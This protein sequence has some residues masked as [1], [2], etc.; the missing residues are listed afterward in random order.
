[1][2]S[3]NKPHVNIPEVEMKNSISGATVGYGNIPLKS[4]TNSSMPEINVSKTPET[5]FLEA[6]E[7]Y[8]NYLHSREKLAKKRPSDYFKTFNK[9]QRAVLHFPILEKNGINTWQELEAEAER[10]DNKESTLSSTD[11]DM[12]LN[13]HTACLIEHENYLNNGK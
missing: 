7:K 2:S 1:M 11:R 8:L 6:K 10:I 5:F 13:V 12:V 3:K 9:R 4:M